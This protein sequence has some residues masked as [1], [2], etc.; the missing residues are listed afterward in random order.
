M[1]PLLQLSAKQ[2]LAIGFVLVF[3]GFL[4]PFL[5]VLRY[6]PTTFFLAFLTYI[7]SLV[8]LIFGVLGAAMMGLER[9]KRK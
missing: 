9:R 5:M 8:G 2:F 7:M 4:L 1:A 6:I 3:L